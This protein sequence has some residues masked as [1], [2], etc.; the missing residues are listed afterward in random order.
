MRRRRQ[1]GYRPTWRGAEGGRGRLISIPFSL[2][3]SARI[4]IYSVHS[5][6]S[7]HHEYQAQRVIDLFLL[8]VVCLQI[9][10]SAGHC[11]RWPLVWLPSAAWEQPGCSSTST[12]GASAG[13]STGH[14]S[15]TGRPTRWGCMFLMQIG[16]SLAGVRHARVQKCA[17]VPKQDCNYDQIVKYM[18]LPWWMHLYLID[19]R[20]WFQIGIYATVKNKKM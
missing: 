4:N 16:S 5:E 3:P 20:Q 11:S 14:I 18:V 10:L 13:R 9:I 12:G 2:G 6:S 19:N 15:F 7:V 8:A 1:R 17:C